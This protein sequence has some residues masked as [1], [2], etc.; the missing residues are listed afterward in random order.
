[1]GGGTPDTNRSS[2][3]NGS[4]NW[5]SPS[6]LGDKIYLYE[7]V[8]K[9]S[10]EG[11]ANS[12][13][14]I[15]PA[16]KTILFTSRASIGLAAILKCAGCTNQGFQSIVVNNPNSVYF[17]FSMKEK[18]KQWAKRQASGSTFLEISGKRLASMPLLIPSTDEQNCLGTFMCALDNNI[19]LHQRKP[20]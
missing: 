19:T 3:W 7:S 10:L 11:L 5:F 20:Y 12:S 4:V 15:L 1:M 2:Y 9:I 16:E 6:E 17:I 14:K 18:M 13:A 8:R